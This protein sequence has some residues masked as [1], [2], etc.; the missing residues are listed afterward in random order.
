MTPDPARLERLLGLVSDDQAIDWDAE[1]ASAQSTDERRALR[2]LRLVAQ[3]A[4]LHDADPWPTLAPGQRVGRFEILGRIGRGAH[5]D[6]YRA[7][8]PHLEREVAL[9]I[10]PEGRWI[11]PSTGVAVDV[12]TFLA[13]ARRL[14]SVRHPNV[15]TIHGIESLPL[16]PGVDRPALVMEYVAG[17]SVAEWIHARGALGGTE[18]T[19]VG[20]EL[21]R[22]LAAVHA[23]GLVHQDVKA[24]N[25]RRE[26]GGRIVLMDF[27]PG[28]ATPLYMAPELFRG[29]RASI[30]SDLYAVGVLLFNAAT[31]KY[32]VHGRDLESLRA[33]HA[34]G[35]RSHLRD[36]RPELSAALVDGIERALSVDPAAR[37]ASAGEMEAALAASMRAGTMPIA[38]PTAAPTAAPLDTKS[39]P[40]SSRRFAPLAAA[41]LCAV[42][43]AIV[44]S[45]RATDESATGLGPPP[46]ESVESVGSVGAESRPFTIGA[47]LMRGS[48]SGVQLAPGDGVAPGDSL[49]VVFENSDSLYVYVINEDEQGESYLLYPH[50]DVTPRNPLAPGSHSL[51]GRRG[52]NRVFWRVTSAGG[53]ERFLLVASRRAL[54]SLDPDEL[55]LDRPE[56]DRV[57]EYTRVPP[58]AVAMLRGVGGMVETDDR[59]GRSAREQL[60][61]LATPLPS[62]SETVS[63]VWMRK[64]EV[65]NPRR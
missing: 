29:A 14:A 9:K 30:R 8:D 26:A 23:A 51:P 49:S 11:D 39:R 58:E 27:G 40:S 43:L 33:A 34:A 38:A 25:V 65:E 41:A 22:A 45:R 21:C 3:I 60:F 52:G 48:G 32:P 20:L 42:V 7:R 46:V 59:E 64:I 12:P 19:G 4:E 37:F 62:R 47:R 56:R 54:P 15:V 63:G 61:D 10:F 16:A 53:T 44:L 28:G 50:A 24:Q 2:S 1:E 18:A 35:E 57:V 36:L 6:V 13:E 17:E 55:G 5:G 31:G